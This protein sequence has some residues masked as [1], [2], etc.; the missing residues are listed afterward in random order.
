MGN[1]SIIKMT[2]MVLLI[3]IGAF[4]TVACNAD[5]TKNDTNKNEVTKAVTEQVTPTKQVSPT[6]QPTPTKCS[7]LPPYYIVFGGERKQA[8]KVIEENLKEYVV[9]TITEY[10]GDVYVL[11]TEEGQTNFTSYVGCEYAI[12]D[13]EWYLYYK[14]QWLLMKSNTENSNSD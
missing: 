10:T 13:E 6:G 12:K 11:P 5:D 3:A 8:L 9:G 14:G 1:F 2:A 7:D 4:A